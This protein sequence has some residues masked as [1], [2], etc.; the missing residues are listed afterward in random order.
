MQSIIKQQ[1]SVLQSYEKKLCHTNGLK[2]FTHLSFSNRDQ[3]EIKTKKESG[4][5]IKI[6]LISGETGGERDEEQEQ[7]KIWRR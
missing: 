3:G 2:Y 6:T 4:E 1:G 5:A 7:V